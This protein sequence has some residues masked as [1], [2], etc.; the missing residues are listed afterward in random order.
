MY[1]LNDHQ[2]NVRVVIGRQR[3]NNQAEVLAYMDYDAMGNIL[4]GRAYYAENYR[5]GYQGQEVNDLLGWNEFEA[6]MYDPG[7]GRWLVPDPAGQFHSPYLAMG[8]AG[9]YYTDPDGRLVNFIIGALVGGFSGWQI[10]K[11]HGAKGLDMFGYIIG[12]ASVGTITSG[13]A[14][15]VSA[16][17][18]SA[19]AASVA[20]GAIGGA[21]LVD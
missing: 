20:A 14:V 13:V 12:G 21:D 4:P 3:V 9:H 7:L 6:R 17:S 18:G 16:I 8:N 5:F 1:E 10:G 11:A 2:G 15:G 19:I